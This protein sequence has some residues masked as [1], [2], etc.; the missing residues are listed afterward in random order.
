MESVRSRMNKVDPRDVFLLERMRLQ[1]KTSLKI[2][3]RAS[4]PDRDACRVWLSQKMKD[5]KSVQ[6]LL[7][8]VRSEESK[9]AGE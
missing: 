7:M 3:R 4:I 5:D 1:N 6:R 2:D 9:D 8:V